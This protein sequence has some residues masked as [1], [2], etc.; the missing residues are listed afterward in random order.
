MIEEEQDFLQ[1]VKII[2]NMQQ[3]INC[4]E[5]TNQVLIRSNHQLM[6][7]V[8]DTI[9]ELEDYKDNVRFE[10]ED[11]L[12]H[13]DSFW[14]P[15]IEPAAAA[16][17]KIVHEGCSM[18]RFG[19][20][21]F[22]A[23]AGRIRH[24]FQTVVNEKLAQRLVEVLHA[25]EDGLLIGIA[26][27]YGNLQKYNDQAKREIRRYLKRNVRREHLALLEK[28]VCYYDAYVTRPYVMYADNDTD[29]PAER[30]KNLKQIW[31]QKDCIFVEGNQ[32]RLGVGNDLFQN[33]K[34][35]KRILA[36]SVN[37]FEAYDRI[38]EA[39]ICQPKDQLFLLALGPTA[40]VLAY[41]LYKAGFQAVDVGHIDLEYEWFLK[42]EGRRTP[43]EGKYNN[44]IAGGDKPESIQD[45]HYCTQ[46]IADF[47]K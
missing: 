30:F 47:S 37:A 21:E 40:T 31:E 45:K 44:E 46:V 17:D 18:A 8:Q 13:K 33:T 38:Y 35:I 29:A 36:P 20:G 14:Y 4:L 42:G 11:E 24:K 43:I 25:K 41:D 26:D 5:Q 3:R 27:N 34:S 7:W 22:A 19:D 23:M 1:L 10:I 2:E 9:D 16:I 28:N 15:H 32:T 39:C 6:E 12:E